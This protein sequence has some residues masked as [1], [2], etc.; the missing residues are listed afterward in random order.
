MLFQLRLPDQRSLDDPPSPSDVTCQGERL[1][2]T[3]LP[4]R[5]PIALPNVSAL[6][7]LQQ[8]GNASAAQ[9]GKICFPQFL[10]LRGAG[11][12]SS[13]GMI[14]SCLTRLSCQLSHSALS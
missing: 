14:P 3:I 2:I 4:C 9:Q 8:R 13:E 1:L 12:G 11:L 7:F 10:T 5:W 6:G